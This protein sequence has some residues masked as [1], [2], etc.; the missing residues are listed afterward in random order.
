MPVSAGGYME[1]RTSERHATGV[2][3]IAVDCPANAADYIKNC[4]CNEGKAQHIYRKEHGVGRNLPYLYHKEYGA[5]N[6]G[7]DVE[8]IEAA[9]KAELFQQKI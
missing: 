3:K 8:H 7:A 5:G 1:A 4:K 2:W 6:I 9:F